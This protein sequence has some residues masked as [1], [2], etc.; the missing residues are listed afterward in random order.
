MSIQHRKEWL[1]THQTEL[2]QQIDT[3]RTQIPGDFAQRV[4]GEKGKDGKD[5]QSVAEGFK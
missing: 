1:I 4:E 2:S 3:S 5:E